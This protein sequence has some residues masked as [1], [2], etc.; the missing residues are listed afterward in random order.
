[1]NDVTRQVGGA[2]GVAVIGSL[3]ATAYTNDMD[4][5]AAAAAS[6]IGGAH[7]VA[8]QLG[9]AAGQ[10]LADERRAGF[11][12]ALGL[13][14]TVAAAVAFAGAVLVLRRLPDNRPV[15]SAAAQPAALEP[16]PAAR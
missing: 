16:L 6:P 14:L 2:L 5:A 8:A 9:G 11:T 4:G 3:I 12:D 13:G 1:M 15:A 10:E 7:A